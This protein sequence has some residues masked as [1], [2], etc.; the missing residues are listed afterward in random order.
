[1]LYFTL[2]ERPEAAAEEAALEEESELDAEE[3]VEAATWV[4]VTTSLDVATELEL[5]RMAVTKVL[6]PA[7]VEDETFPETTL[8]ELVSHSP[9]AG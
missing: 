7:E 6:E 9:K 1:M 5:V 4:E 8:E 2:V 3:V